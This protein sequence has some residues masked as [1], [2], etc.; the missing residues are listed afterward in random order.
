MLYIVKVYEEGEVFEY[1]YGLLEH[2]EEHL[3]FEKGKA[4]LYT[5]EN[6]KETLMK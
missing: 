2:A 6:G 4:E 1:E 3:S 5:Y